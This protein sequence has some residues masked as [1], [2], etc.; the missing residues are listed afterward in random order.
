MKEKKEDIIL[1]HQ[2]KRR[3]HKIKLT[4]ATGVFI[5][6]GIILIGIY[7]VSN[8]QYYTEYKETAYTK[9]FMIKIVEITLQKR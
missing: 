1:Y 9:N 7:I 6:I 8:K 3:R 5:V 2:R 4:I